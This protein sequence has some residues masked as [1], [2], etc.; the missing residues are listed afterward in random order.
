VSRRADDG[1][2]R[3]SVTKKVFDQECARCVKRILGQKDAFMLLV[4]NGTPISRA[5]YGSRNRG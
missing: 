3:L 4:V 5:E 1:K 2:W